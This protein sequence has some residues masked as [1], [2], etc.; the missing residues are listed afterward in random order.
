MLDHINIFSVQCFVHL[1]NMNILT[2]IKIKKTSCVMSILTSLILFGCV[3]HC[4]FLAVRVV[5]CGPRRG[6]NR[7]GGGFGCLKITF[8]KD[9]SGWG[10]PLRTFNNRTE[11]GRSDGPK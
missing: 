8:Y 11:S 2:L 6:F 9:G 3:Y 10:C 5:G 1:V 7:T 4:F